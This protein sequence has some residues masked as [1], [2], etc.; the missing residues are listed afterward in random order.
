[1]FNIVQYKD[2]TKLKYSL[3]IFY[4]NE[5]HLSYL[6]KATCR[7]CGYNED[8]LYPPMAIGPLEELKFGFGEIKCLKCNYTL[9]KHAIR[10]K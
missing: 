1:M 3:A 9:D 6:R 7:N 2:K 8:I 10:I 4:M 5:Y